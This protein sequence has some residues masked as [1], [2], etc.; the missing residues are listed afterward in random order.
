ML[1]KKTDFLKELAALF[2]LNVFFQTIPK[3]SPRVKKK[4]WSCVQC[5]G[6][7]NPALSEVKL[8][9]PKTGSS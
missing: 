3:D 8:P 2:L 7:S 6:V 1:G 9:P 4:K 5:F